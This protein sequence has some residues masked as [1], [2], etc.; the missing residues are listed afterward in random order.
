MSGLTPDAI[1]VAMRDA[2]QI[3]NLIPVV[4]QDLQSVSLPTSST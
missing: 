3:A 1:T 4:E 2:N